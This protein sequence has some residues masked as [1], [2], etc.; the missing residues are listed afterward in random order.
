MAE[1]PTSTP[2]PVSTPA[3]T[4]NP[5]DNKSPVTPTEEGKGTSLLQ[6]A[7]ADGKPTAEEQ[8]AIEAENKRILDA[9]EKTLSDED[10]AK[11]AE[12]VKAKEKTSADSIPEKYVFKMPEGMTENT[13]LTEALTPVMK[14]LGLTQGKAQKLV[15]VYAS[16]VQ[17][18]AVKASETARQE[19][20]EMVAGWG[21]DAV[22]TL[23]SE[24]VDVAKEMAFAAKAKDK[25]ASPELLAILSDEQSG[26]GNHVELLKMFI[27]IG[28]AISSDSFPDG[29]KGGGRND[30][31]EAV[32]ERMY[33]TMKKGT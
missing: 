6:E 5:T 8:A 10:K 17:K 27:K 29:S 4:L 7:G 21:K 31:V 9:D 16:I 22:K 24:G 11:R 14:E 30:S 13:E 23:S 19:F 15:D 25:F 26:L 12:L 2:A 20:K 32:A 18:Q 1:T 3:P 28:K 33:P